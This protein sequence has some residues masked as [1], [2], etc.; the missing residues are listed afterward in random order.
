[1]SEASPSEGP[2]ASTPGPPVPGSAAAT[3]RRFVA[4]PV[5]AEV[6]ERLAASLP[7][8]PSVTDGVRWTR[9]ESWHLTL[10]FL[11]DVDDRR[12]DHLVHTLKGGVAASRVAPRR[13]ALDQL[14]TFGKRVLWIGVDASPEASLHVLADGVR[15]ALRRGGYAVVDRPLRAHVT[16]ARAGRRPVTR[17][18]TDACAAAITPDHASTLAW[19]PNAIEVWRSTLGSG[20]ARYATEATIG[21]QHG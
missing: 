15:A 1:M 2:G 5:P 9:P 19:T 3:P 17:T 20:P 21:L 7:T 16:L 4:L 6:R 13:L 12:F 11:G 10:A 8:E 14:G 18:L